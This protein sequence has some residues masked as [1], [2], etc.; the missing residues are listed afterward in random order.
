MTMTYYI[1]Q[2]NMCRCYNN[3]LI[4]QCAPEIAW[5][6]EMSAG[7]KASNNSNS[8]YFKQQL[9]IRYNYFSPNLR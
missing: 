5:P 6:R 8:L 2:C 3:G 4:A 9:N 1:I 7:A